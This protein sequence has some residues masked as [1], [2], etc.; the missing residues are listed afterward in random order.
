MLIRAQ[1]KRI[2][3]TPSII[4]WFRMMQSRLKISFQNFQYDSCAQGS[5]IYS[6]LQNIFQRNTYL[7]FAILIHRE[8]K[9]TLRNS[10]MENCTEDSNLNGIRNIWILICMFCIQMYVWNSREQ[11]DSKQFKS[12]RMPIK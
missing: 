4:H 5:F 7:H 3:L 1:P 8:I 9:M 11:F 2:L 12:F 6:R 10:R